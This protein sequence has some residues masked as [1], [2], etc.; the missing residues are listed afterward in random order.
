MKHFRSSLLLSA[1]ISLLA[2]TASAVSATPNELLGVEPGLPNTAFTSAFGSTY[3]NEQSQTLTIH[4]IPT[5]TFFPPIYAHEPEGEVSLTIEL[6]NSG[7]V[8]AGTFTLTGSVDKYNGDLIVGNVLSMG[9]ID[10]PHTDLFDF[11]LSFT[12]GEL[13][14]LYQDSDIGIKLT[15]ENSTFNG[16]FNESWQGNSK[17]NIGPID[18]Q[19]SNA[20]YGDTVWYDDNQNGLQD[21]IEQGVA[22]VKVTLYECG[23]DELPGTL[24]DV[25][26]AYTESDVDGLY[27]FP[28]VEPGNYYAQFGNIPA[29]FIFTQQNQGLSDLLDSDVDVN[30]G[31]VAC[32]DIEADENDMS[33]D[34][35]IHQQLPEH[36]NFSVSCDDFSI[37]G[38]ISR[39]THGATISYALTIIDSELG[40]QALNGSI[41]VAGTSDAMSQFN[42]SE[43]LSLELSEATISGSVVIEKLDESGDVIDS[44]TINLDPQELICVNRITLSATCEGYS[45]SGKLATVSDI[46]TVRYILDVNDKVSGAHRIDKEIKLAGSDSSY[47]EFNSSKPFGFALSDA[48]ISGVAYWEKLDTNNEVIERGTETLESQ[49]VSCEIV[50]PNE[51]GKMWNDPLFAGGDG[52]Y[53]RFDGVIKKPYNFLTDTNLVVTTEF[54][55]RWNGAA[56]FATEFILVV[57][58]DAGTKSDTIHY[59]TPTRENWGYSVKINGVEMSKTQG[60]TPLA[61]GGTIRRWYNTIYLTTAEGY[62][63]VIRQAHAAV[64]AK[65]YTSTDG[66]NHGQLPTGLIGQTF[67][68]DNVKTDIVPTKTWYGEFTGD[69]NGDGKADYLWVRNGVNVAITNNDGNAFESKGEGFPALTPWLPLSTE[70]SNGKTKVTYA[71]AGSRFVIDVNNDGLDD[72]VWYLDGWNVAKSN[73][74]GFDQPEEWIPAIVTL[75]SGAKVGTTK[76]R[77]QYL[78]DMNGDGL[79]DLLWN[80][81]GWNVAL[82]D[83][84]SFTQAKNWL[85][86]RVNVVGGTH[87]YTYNAPYT[88]VAD[89]NGDGSAD[90][91]WNRG[92]WNVALS[93]GNGFEPAKRW[94]TNRAILENGSR[95]ITYNAPYQ[96]V[97]DFNGDGAADLM[98]NRAGWN[99]ALSTKDGFA[100]PKQWLPNYVNPS[101]SNSSRQLSFNAGYQHF[102]DFN[103]DGNTDYLWYRNGWNVSLSNGNGFDNPERLIGPTA[104]M[105]YRPKPEA[106]YGVRRNHF[107]DL[108]GDGSLDLFWYSTG[109]RAAINGAWDSPFV[110]MTKRV[111]QVK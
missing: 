88:Y 98:W 46:A 96:M 68:A 73:G 100:Q 63:F 38:E 45:V 41:T 22:K 15:V 105:Q 29:G 31:N 66:V 101:N 52:D 49:D 81:N 18:K 76:A 30:S 34:A 44:K 19:I 77:Y 9:Y 86:H 87:Q 65:V 61:D 6:D 54:D 14:T 32:T 82:S 78:A 107:A 50:A 80:M 58:N 13:S 16:N 28:N 5:S 21:D 64:Y 37:S 56:T 17:G 110:W 95:Q 36:V 7:S 108:N 106:T 70:L 103:N 51:E 99:V 102:V 47:T 92:G 109:W 111:F 11:R 10:N 67:D 75:A 69:F 57:T 85:P 91:M 39:V 74:Q 43:A 72:Y 4:S 2:N 90:L 12:H 84:S 71:R 60:T 104:L 25:K 3:Y 35:G 79:V 20:S 83:G 94:L 89:F 48:T 24:D 42:I 59:H 1:S 27:L 26:V 93:T 8:E 62:E 97:G 55:S 23:I 33:W 53:F 40:P